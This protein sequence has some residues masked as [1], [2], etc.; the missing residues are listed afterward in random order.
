MPQAGLNRRSTLPFGTPAP[1]IPLPR[2]AIA[3]A[4]AADEPA[5]AV[6]ARPA[7][8]ISFELSGESVR[9]PAPAA[10]GTLAPTTSDAAPQTALSLA[11]RNDLSVVAAAQFR[12]TQRSN[13]RLVVTC[14]VVSAAAASLLTFWLA[15]GAAPAPSPSVT[16]MAEP[17][18]AAAPPAAAAPQ[19]LT[20]LAPTGPEQ[21][22]A[23]VTSPDAPSAVP[24]PPAPPKAKPRKARAA[25]AQPI[26]RPPES[27]TD[28]SSQPNP[29]A[30]KLEDQPSE[31]QK[32]APAAAEKTAAESP[33][34]PDSSPPVLDLTQ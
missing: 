34:E 3:P 12:A 13:K 32:P 30:A 2:P 27:E 17:V 19:P 18:A 16:L 6:Y 4:P 21:S 24:A 8:T 20:A 10:P 9:G 22:S 11:P 23:N 33:A 7:A 14:S 25:R 15:R 28:P 5:L 31:G 1:K 26:A 29:Y